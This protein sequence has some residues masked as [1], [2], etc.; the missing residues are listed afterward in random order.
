MGVLRE[1][2]RPSTRMTARFAVLA[3]GLAALGID[4]SLCQEIPRFV[5]PPPPA[6][7]QML[8]GPWHPAK[9]DPGPR[10]SSEDV[11]SPTDPA[12]KLQPTSPHVPQSLGDIDAWV[13][14]NLSNYGC[15]ERRYYGVPG[16]FA[17]VMRCD[18]VACPTIW[19]KVKEFFLFDCHERRTHS[20][21]V[22]LLVTEAPPEPQP[23]AATFQEVNEQ[24]FSRGQPA[25]P[26]SVAQQPYGAGVVCTTLAYVFDLGNHRLLTD[27]EVR[28]QDVNAVLW[29]A[30]EKTPCA[31]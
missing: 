3:V 9:R 4:S 1:S 14:H 23:R 16:G 27:V 12:Q 28:E 26:M 5:P 10:P 21:V 18:P 25:L 11:L 24:W 22:L 2:E 13:V 17:V 15:T 19:E 7:S 6:A 30:L 29:L 8:A 20:R 31:P